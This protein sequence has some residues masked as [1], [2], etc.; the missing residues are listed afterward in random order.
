MKRKALLPA[1]LLASALFFSCGGKTSALLWTD[2]PEFALYAQIYNS[3]QSRYKIDVKYVAFPAERLMETEEV[4]D[5]VAGAFLNSIH[6][7]ALFQDLSFLFGKGSI[8]KDSFYDELLRLGAVQ[9]KQ[10]LLPVSFNIP[11][12]L[13]KNDGNTIPSHYVIGDVDELRTLGAEYNENKN[14]DWMRKGFSPLWGRG[15]GG[16]FLFMAARLFGMDL[17]EVLNNNSKKEIMLAWD[18]EKLEEFVRY[19]K[20]WI[21]LNGGTQAEDDFI[22]KYFFNLPPKLLADGRIRFAYAKS[23]DYFL[24]PQDANAELDFRWLTRGHDLPLTEDTALFGIHKKSAA[25]NVAA[26]FARWFFDDE[27]HNL[28]LQESRDNHLHETSFG[29][30]GGLSAMRTVTEFVFPKYYLKLLGHVPPA[31]YLSAPAPLPSSWADIKEYVVVPY[32]LD[33]I[34]GA[35]AENRSLKERLTEWRTLKRDAFR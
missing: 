9:N 11:A 18:D 28:L 3:S 12:I 22:Y 16:E 31:E 35:P 1:A 5:M 8:D 34:R 10:Y 14:G 27:T 17:E 23:N 7:M 29:I 30:A 6:A 13:F 4:P 24:L 15:R 19:I 33:A 2:R 32:M 25:R 26:D 21:E 20:E